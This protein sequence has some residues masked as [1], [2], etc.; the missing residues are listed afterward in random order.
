MVDGIGGDEGFQADHV[1]GRVGAPGL[2]EGEIG[3]IPAGDQPDA[4]GARG[5]GGLVDPG[6]YLITVRINGR[7]YKQS[8]VIE[9]PIST[10][11]L[12]GGW[13]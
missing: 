6:T 10:S 8:A 1:P 13:Q 12:T 5:A 9:R 3:G 4:V 11:A 2:V 7:D